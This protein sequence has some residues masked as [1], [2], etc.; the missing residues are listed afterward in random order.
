MLHDQFEPRLR[1]AR[2]ARPI[3]HTKSADKHIVYRQLVLVCSLKSPIRRALPPGTLETV[4][5]IPPT[6]TMVNGGLRLFLDPRKGAS[7]PT[8][9]LKY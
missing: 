6:G 4:P 7:S 8:N 1:N 2:S 5:P 9:L 3:R